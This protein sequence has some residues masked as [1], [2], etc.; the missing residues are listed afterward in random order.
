MINMDYNLDELDAAL[1]EAGTNPSP[2]PAPLRTAT[3]V[4][5]RPRVPAA[6]A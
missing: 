3:P 6:A 5:G 4:V 1:S 2:W